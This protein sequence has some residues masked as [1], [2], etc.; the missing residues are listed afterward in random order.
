M[1][2]ATSNISGIQ[3]GKNLLLLCYGDSAVIISLMNA[4][5]SGF[6][7]HFGRRVGK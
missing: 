1:L 3:C 6:D 4:E 2:L 5:K 7:T